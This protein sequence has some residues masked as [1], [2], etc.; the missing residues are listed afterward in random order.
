MGTGGH[1]V[2]LYPL[3]AFLAQGA[4][5]IDTALC[6]RGDGRYC[7]LKIFI[8]HLKDHAGFMD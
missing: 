6:R 7:E 4:G 1:K 5:R 8:E 3:D 2:D